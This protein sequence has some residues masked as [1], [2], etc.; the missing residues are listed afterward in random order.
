MRRVYISFLGTNDYVECIYESG[1]GDAKN[2][3]R[4]VQETTLSL[5]SENANA[6]DRGFIFITDEARKKN[7]EDDGQRDREKKCNKQ[8][9]GLKNRIDLLN[10]PFPVEAIP[11]PEGHSE[12]E[13]W[14]IFQL[15]FGI[16]KED[17]EVVFDITH[18]FRSIPMLAIVILN[19]A[20]VLKNIRLLGIYYGAFE[21]LGPS[22]EVAKMP[23]EERRAPLL[24]LSS[25]NR[26]MEWTFAVDRFLEAGDAKEV[27]RLAREAAAPILKNSRGKDTGASATRGIANALEFFSKNLNTCRGP[28]VVKAAEYLKSELNKAMN[29]EDVKPLVPLFEHIRKRVSQF[30]GDTVHDGVQAAK[31][32]LDHNLIQ[33]GYTILQET[34]ITH[35]VNNNEQDSGVID[36]RNI[37]AAAVWFAKDDTPEDKWYGDAGKDRALTIKYIRMFKTME[38]LSDLYRQMKPYRDDLLHAGYRNDPKKPDD[39]KIKLADLIPKVEAM[40]ES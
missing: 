2:P 12:E 26:L 31:W 10:L 21:A 30:R 7:W 38:G 40:I 37:A 9:Q 20:R 34:L 13:I 27:S 19:Y 8:C 14:D 29:V 39:F 15:V 32:C 24:N 23:V 28:I 17:D 36:N 16:L 25:L 35:F 33:Q 3:V 22:W 18:A 1:I 4:F 11:I 6:D 5:F